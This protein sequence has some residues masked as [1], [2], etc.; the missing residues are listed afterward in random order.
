MGSADCPVVLV[1]GSCRLSWKRLG[2]LYG[3]PADWVA[4]FDGQEWTVGPANEVEME[5]EIFKYGE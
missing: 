5:E 3:D 1:S 2:R 4:V